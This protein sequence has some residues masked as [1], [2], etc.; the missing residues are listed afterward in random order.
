VQHLPAVAAARAVAER[1]RF[2]ERDAQVRMPLAQCH[3]VETPVR[4]PPITAMSA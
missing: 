1:A 4:P 3:A 2:E